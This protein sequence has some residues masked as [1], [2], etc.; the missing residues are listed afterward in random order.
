MLEANFTK[1]I[2]AKS[3]KWTTEDVVNLSASDRDLVYDNVTEYL[4][5]EEIT[6]EFLVKVRDAYLESDDMLT[7]GQVKGVINCIRASLAKEEDTLFRTNVKEIVEFYDRTFSQAKKPKLTIAWEGKDYR[8][9]RAP[10]T[11]KNAGSL[12]VKEI[13]MEKNYSPADLQAQGITPNQW[14]SYDSYLGKIDSTGEVDRR[15]ERNTLATE[16]LQDLAE[17]PQ[18]AVVRFGR[19]RGQ[20]AIC[21]RVL[22]R[23]DSIERGIGP[24]CA[25]MIGF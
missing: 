8:I 25:G 13:N 10:L 19:L 23:Q 24:V 2:T 4:E 6:F 20:C 5:T 3:E 15:L 9:T 22:D 21:S 1:L 16:M 14:G 11:G 7:V 18:A 17:D 12:Y